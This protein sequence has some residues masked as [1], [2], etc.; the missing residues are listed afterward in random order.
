MGDETYKP[1][2]E[3]QS[4]AASDKDARIAADLLGTGVRHLDCAP[5][6]IQMAAQRSKT[7]K[8]LQIPKSE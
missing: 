6:H 3:A 4:P 5:G 2:I 1:E 7:G 8:H